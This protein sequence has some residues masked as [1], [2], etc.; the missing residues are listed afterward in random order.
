MAKPRNYA[1]EY[2]KYQGTPEQIK[3]RSERNKARRVYEKKNGDLPSD[4][5]VDHKK[6][7]SKGG[8]S[9]PSNLR[10][11]SKSS[12]R[13]FARTNTGAMKSQKSLRE[14]KK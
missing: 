9:S 14:S 6:A 5:D 2:A 4:V 1:E 8:T 11:V 3:N 12:N 13:S 10:A 7:L